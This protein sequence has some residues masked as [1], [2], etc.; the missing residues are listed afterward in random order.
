MVK[1][2]TNGK[3]GHVFVKFPSSVEEITPEYLK[4]VTDEIDV[5]DN[6][7]LIALCHKEKLST[8]IAASRNKSNQIST[9]VIPIIA[10]Q[11]KTDS[12]FHTEMNVG[13]IILIS[14]SQMAMGLHVNVPKNILNMN[15]LIKAT[16]GDGYAHKNAL[17]YS[18]YVYFLEFKLVP[19]CDIIGRYNKT[20]NKEFDN[21][22]ALETIKEVE[23]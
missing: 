16:D 3:H 19:N 4:G 1:F 8:F 17:K 10:K 13:D 6:Y 7:T 21:P 14:P 5:A 22:F 12:V 18:Q 11:G 2:E 23:E 15:H 20:N 9:S